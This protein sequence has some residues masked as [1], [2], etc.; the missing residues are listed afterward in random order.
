MIPPNQTIYE[1]GHFQL[2]AADRCLFCRDK[3]ID[4]EP[5]VFATLLYLVENYGH[6]VSKK[7]IM[8]QVWPDEFVE[9]NNVPRHIALLRKKLGGEQEQYIETIPKIGYRFVAEVKL[10]QPEEQPSPDAASTP[11]SPV[12]V[13]AATDINPVP[14]SAATSDPALVMAQPKSRRPGLLLLWPTTVALVGIGFWIAWTIYGHV[15]ILTPT[16]KLTPFTTFPGLET[17]PALSPDGERVAFVW[18]GA[19]GDNF[20]IYVKPVISRN[21]GDEVPFRLTT[22]ASRDG[23]P[24]WSPNGREIAFLRR[25]AEGGEFLA[26]PAQG[27]RERRLAEASSPRHEGWGRNLD[28]SPDG[29]SLAIVDRNSPS[30]PLSLFLVSTEHGSRQRLTSPPATCV[31]DV[32]PAFSPDGQTVAFM[33]SCS[34]AI[35]DIHLAPVRGG[36]PSRLTHDNGTITGLAWTPDGREIIF[37]SNREGGFRLWRVAAPGGEPQPLLA[38]VQN[39]VSPSLSRRM[40]R[41]VF[42]QEIE[43]TNIWRLGLKPPQREQPPAQLIASTHRED[44]P[45]F[46]PDGRRIAFQS[47]RS[48]S[49]ELWLCDSDGQRP[50]QLTRF[51]GP[52][53]GCPRWSP[54]GLQLAFDSAHAGSHRDIYVI[55]AD[56]SGLRRLTTESSN[57]SRPSWSHDGKWIYFASNRSGAWQV[58]RA[59]AAGGEAVQVT[60]HGGREAFESPDGHFIYYAKGLEHDWSIWRVPVDGSEEIQVLDQAHQGYWALFE[61]G[62][63]LLNPKTTAI[64]FFS[65]ATRQRK[66]LAEVKKE[67][68][69]SGPGFSVSPDQRWILYLQTDLLSSDLTLADNFR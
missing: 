31:G 54:D 45:R 59:P 5:K 7:Q 8:G 24:V 44:A 9:E 42:S 62:I 64:E 11:V 38:G 53:V 3:V 10:V 69:W 13:E 50:V 56:G 22:D 17:A 49:F 40:A 48:G 32:H 36:E 52:H 28:W 65:F 55:N 35:Y 16:L 37:S 25:G 18:N 26:A 6:T 23:D 2:K 60:R 43:D 46:S 47:T 51:G 21:G 34:N 66:R 1:F 27:G 19:G 4:L 39:A 20:D 29:K 14:T 67:L 30:D 41:L 33:R 58:W 12:P 63:Y 15:P 57:D 61:E 68:D